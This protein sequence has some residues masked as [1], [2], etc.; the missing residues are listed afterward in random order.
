[1][2]AVDAEDGMEMKA[3]CAP[4]PRISDLLTALILA[5]APQQVTLAAQAQNPEADKSYPDKPIRIIV[6]FPP[7]GS[8]DILGRFMGQRLSELLGQQAVIDN[9]AGADGII[10]T[11]IAAKSTPDGYTL[12][13]IS[14]SYAMNPAI[15]NKL[16]YDS[17]R[18]FAP[19]ALFGVGP[20]VI[21]AFPGFQANTL[22][23][24][25]VLAKARPGQIQYASSGIGGFNHFGGELFKS[26]AKVDLVHV[27]YKGGGPAMVDVIG[28][29]VPVLLST[30]VQALPQIRQG[31]LR[32]LGVGGDK[33]S[34]ALPEVPTIA[35][36]GV[37]GYECTN[38]WGLLAPTGIAAPRVARLN[39]AINAI[40]KEPEAKKRLAQEA[41][42]PEPTTPQVFGKLIAKDISKWSKVAREADIRAQ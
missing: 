21:S 18:A 16:P 36:A 42:E 26:L 24:L 5:T 41:T 28:G 17:V 33:R 20:N 35:E 9:R 3:A 38:W 29:H 40:L 10:G 8:N 39:Q 30:L 25:I 11:E 6:P 15:H 31:K 22:K 1:M 12:L 19:I 27:P 2:T 13:V 32:A 23:E 14:A 7:G 4:Y 34:P 37:P